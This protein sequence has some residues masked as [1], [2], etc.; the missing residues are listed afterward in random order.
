MQ[1][2]IK[3]DGIINKFPAIT[4]I[5]S[6]VVPYL[7]F[8]NEYFLNLELSQEADSNFKINNKYFKVIMS[9]AGTKAEHVMG[10]ILVQE[11]NKSGT[12]VRVDRDF[13][14]IEF[15]PEHGT[16]AGMK[17]VQNDTYGE[18]T[19]IPVTYV[20][21]ETLQNGPY[22]GK[23]CWWIADGPEINFHIHPAF[24]G[25]DGHPHNLRIAS[26][27]TSKK[28][29]LPFSEDKGNNPDGYWNNISYNTLHT[30]DLPTNMRPYSIYDHH[31]LARM[32]LT[33]FGTSD[34]QIQTVD[35]VEWIGNNRITYHGIHDPFGTAN[36]KEY[37]WL[38]GLTTLNGTYQVLSANGNH[39]MVET[40]VKCPDTGVWPINYYTNKVNDIDFGDIFIANNKNSDN[41][42]GSFADHQYLYSRCAFFIHWSSLN[43]Q[44]AFYLGSVVPTFENDPV[45]W[46]MSWLVED[47][48]ETRKNIKSVQSVSKTVNYGTTF[49]NIELPNAVTA[50]LDDNT[51]VDLPV[52][53]NSSTYNSTEPGQQN[54]T[55]SL[56]LAD[57]LTNINDVK[58]LAII[59]V[60]ENTSQEEPKKNIKSIESISKSVNYGT[61]FNSIGL[62]NTITVTLDDD[63]TISLSVTWKSDS[64]IE[65]GSFVQYIPGTLT[66]TDNLTNTNNIEPVAVVTVSE[67]TMDPVNNDDWSL[68]FTLG[69]IESEVLL[70]NIPGF[71][72]KDTPADTDFYG[73]DYDNIGRHLEIRYLGTQGNLTYAP[74]G[75]PVPNSCSSE[76]E[77]AA[78]IN[79]DGIADYDPDAG[80][81]TFSGGSAGIKVYML[82]YH[83]EPFNS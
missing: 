57:N 62:P 59:T 11:G 8:N 41:E 51:T 75:V 14:T 5:E 52:N 73:E 26:W 28:N 78:A 47:E 32:M 4:D 6:A 54:I 68:Q 76:E 7:S 30:M 19:E 31:F 24:I 34:V 49:N 18:F 17:Q 25:V 70:S 22:A 58:A 16:W 66:L 35:G 48:G 61:P 37:L 39:E 50:T 1:F 64:Y 42:S 67:Q 82:V 23:N 15:N 44:G 65:T 45:G 27:I 2:Q 55:G 43:H 80:N 20:K 29:N 46:R 77:Q 63:S 3:K 60:T 40:G 83:S 21:T 36:G 9:P 79:P 33:E 71:S 53:W 10:M 72:E 38:D 69:T 56:I 12:W 81:I 13:N 74:D